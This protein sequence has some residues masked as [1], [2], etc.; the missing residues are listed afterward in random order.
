MAKFS[1]EKKRNTAR[2]FNT[3]SEENMLIKYM[4][5]KSRAYQPQNRSKVS[6]MAVKMLKVREHVNKKLKGGRLY[7]KLT[8]PAVVH[9]TP[10]RLPQS[11]WTR[12]DAKVSKYFAV[13]L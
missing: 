2:S 13:Y 8:S 11:F 3:D 7:K 10:N 9:S 1:L 5:N 4:I 6:E 12:F